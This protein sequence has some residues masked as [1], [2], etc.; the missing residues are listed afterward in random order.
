[1]NYILIGK[2]LNTHGIKGDLKVDAFTDFVEERFKKN[3]K[4]Y[5]GEDY[6]QEEVKEY[7]N[8]QSFLLLR[9]V[10]KED[11]NLIEKYKNQYIYKAEE[12]IQRPKE[13]YFF[14]ELKNL[15][16][17]VENKK[18]GIVKNIET[19]TSSNYVR[20]LKENGNEALVP[21]LDHFIL[22]VDLKENRMDIIKMEGLL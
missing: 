22:N 6:I 21:Y 2:I 18:I 4:I 13:G 5:I 1:M 15:D 10:D 11:I 8:H 14:R 3:S 17:Y 19:G 20:V 7:R 16:V 12:D 9:L